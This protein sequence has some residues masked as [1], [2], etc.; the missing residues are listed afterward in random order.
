MNGTTEGKCT[1]CLGD[2]DSLGR[3]ETPCGHCFCTPCYHEL[4]VQDNKC[5]NCRKILFSTGV[6]DEVREA[7]NRV[8]RLSRANYF[9]VMNVSLVDLV[10]EEERDTLLNENDVLRKRIEVLEIEA[11]AEHAAKASA[12]IEQREIN[13]NFTTPSPTGPP[14]RPPPVRR[15]RRA[16]PLLAVNKYSISRNMVLGCLRDNGGGMTTQEIWAT[17]KGAMPGSP[18]ARNPMGSV[19]STLTSLYDQGCVHKQKKWRSRTMKWFFIRR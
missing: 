5:P 6:I 12:R 2:V 18:V 9:N 13:P 4:I 3:C 10:I 1:I 14:S 17:I 19:S 16:R 11:K 7:S 15:R 8:E